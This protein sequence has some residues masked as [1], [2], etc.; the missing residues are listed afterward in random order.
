MTALANGPTVLD[1]D[2]NMETRDLG[3]P[4]KGLD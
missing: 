1:A 4:M 2:V 3:M